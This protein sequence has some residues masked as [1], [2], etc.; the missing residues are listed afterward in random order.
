M[1]RIFGI[2]ALVFVLGLVSFFM[3]VSSEMIV[4]L[5]P[6]FLSDILNASKISIGLIEGVAESTASIL[7][8]ISGWFSDRIGK[9]KPLIFW[10]YSLSVFSRPLLAS[11]TS[12]IGVLVYRFTDRLGKGIR[13]S[14]RDALIAD[15]T[16]RGHMGRAFGF[17]RAMDTLG[18]VVG[19]ALAFFIMAVSS[20]NMRLVFWCSIIPG[21]L[22]IAT[23]AFFVRDTVVKKPEVSQRA[24]KGSFSIKKTIDGRF[25]VFLFIV[26]LFTLGKI[27]EAFLLLRVKE[28]G[29]D[30]RLIPVLYLF[31]NITS[32]FL[33]TPS[34][35]LADRYGKRKVIFASYLV[36]AFIFTGFAFSYG[37]WHAWILFVIYG[38]F[39]AMN[40]GNQRAFVASLIDPEKKATGYGI[41]HTMVGL[42]ALP[43]GLISGTL[44]QLKGSK[45][46]FLYGAVLSL[47]AAFSFYLFLIRNF[48]KINK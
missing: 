21:L 2:P 1:K 12:W 5:M 22:A 35:I 36:A 3:D 23:I 17:H 10:G 24:V 39:V 32:A 15:V 48:S 6:L 16:E 45:I 44:Y 20:N 28:L 46:V 27:P 30:V 26:V 4:P 13:T 47:I 42:S 43:G 38:I 31:F 37:E 40:E 11:A 29:V 7:K 34:G 18:A 19:P 25:R 33:A 9:R 8:V 41:Y 14:P